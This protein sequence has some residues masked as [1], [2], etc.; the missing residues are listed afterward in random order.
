LRQA[1]QIA[2]F[3]NPLLPVAYAVIPSSRFAGLFELWTCSVIIVVL[4]SRFSSCDEF[5]S[6]V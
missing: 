4:N 3:G 5:Q 2:G 6:R 1:A